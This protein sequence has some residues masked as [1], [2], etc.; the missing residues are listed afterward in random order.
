MSFTDSTYY[1]GSIKLP[2]AIT[3][4]DLND[5]FDLL[6]EQTE[7]KI[8][9][10]L[11]GY[12]LYKSFIL[13]LAETTP[14]Q[15]WLD[16]RDGKEYTVVDGEGRTVIVKW[17]GLIN[18]EKKSLLA[19]FVYCEYLENDFLHTSTSGANKQNGQNSER[20]TISD[21]NTKSRKA[22]NSGLDLYGYDIERLIGKNAILRSKR[23]Q[24]YLLHDRNVIT[25][26]YTEL[27][28]PTAYNFIYA[29]NEIDATTYPNWNFTI[30]EK[31]NHL[32]I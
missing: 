24:N 5:D 10:D 9:V 16:L 15:K 11:L 26:Y 30:K 23:Y 32:G 6:I 13:G 25:D 2:T 20:A 12:D 28:K 27:L 14:L 3:E 1:K 18:A 22:W 19:F 21:L 17:G 31:I 8:L 4:G 29:M 7:E